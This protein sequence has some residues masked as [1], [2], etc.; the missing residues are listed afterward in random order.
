MDELIALMDNA[1]RTRPDHDRIFIDDSN[2]FNLVSRKKAFETI[3]RESPQ[4]A[5]I[6][7][8]LYSGSTNVWLRCEQDE[9]TTLSSQQ[10]VVQGCVFGPFGFGFGTLDVYRSVIDH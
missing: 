5:R 1:F 8:A 10:G 9:W 4:L 3:L 2:A 6:F 7:H